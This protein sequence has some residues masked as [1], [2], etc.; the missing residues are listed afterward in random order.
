MSNTLYALDESRLR[1][2]IAVGPN[3]QQVNEFK[4]E[5][6]NSKTDIKKDLN[7]G[8]GNFKIYYIFEF[9]LNIGHNKVYVWASSN[10]KNDE[11]KESDKRYVR[12]NG[13]MLGFT[14]G[15]DTNFSFGGV[16]DGKCSLTEYTENYE[17]KTINSSSGSYNMNYLDYGISFA[18]NWEFILGY[19]M[20]N[21]KT[22]SSINSSQ[23]LYDHTVKASF[24]DIGIGYKF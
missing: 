8:A 9:G 6:G 16:I 18:E 5:Q 7:A 17:D 11:D 2:L 15:G 12:G 1:F 19:S 14:L 23:Y 10:D 4:E 24:I 13:L 22:E 20:Y 3:P 21:C